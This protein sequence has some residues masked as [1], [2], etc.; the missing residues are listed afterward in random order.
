MA[1]KLESEKQCDESVEP[2][3]IADSK[4][5]EPSKKVIA[6]IKPARTLQYQGKKLTI[7]E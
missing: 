4:P 7:I 1:E 3:V 5:K 6:E 2:E